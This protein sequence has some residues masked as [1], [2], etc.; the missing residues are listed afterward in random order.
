MA[1][2]LRHEGVA[3]DV[4]EYADKHPGGRDVLDAMDGKSIDEAFEDVGHSKQ[5]RELLRDLKE[6]RGAADARPRSLTEALVT[7]EDRN[8][9]HKL[10]ACANLILFGRAAVLL[11]FVDARHVL[12]ADLSLLHIA[13]VSVAGLLATTGALFFHAPLKRPRGTFSM[14]REQK[15]HTLI[16]SLR[17]C[18]ISLAAP[19]LRCLPLPE[20]WAFLLV[21]AFH[22]AADLLT[23]VLRDAP[24]GGTI[25]DAAASAEGKAPRWV[26]GAASAFSSSMQLG[27]VSQLLDPRAALFASRSYIILVPIQLAAF[28]NTLSKKA[29]LGNGAS[30]ALYACELLLVVWAVEYKHTALGA[31]GFAARR[32]GVPKHFVWLTLAAAHALAR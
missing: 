11:L 6:R 8:A 31:A 32:A 22:A 13:S 27:A 2:L 5:A 16:F 12:F 18:A 23:W 15:M 21:C 19:A 9:L 20:A 29:L 24:E 1:P 3:F 14:T 4:E 7:S 26:V 25:R 17:S 30:S 10:L 28:Q